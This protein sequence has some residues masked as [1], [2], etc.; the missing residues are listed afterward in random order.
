MGTKGIQL[1]FDEDGEPRLA[2]PEEKTAEC[3]A[4]VQCQYAERGED[5]RNFTLMCN[6]NGALCSAFSF[7]RCPKGKWGPIEGLGTNNQIPRA[8]RHDNNTCYTCMTTS[9][10]WQLKPPK[11]EKNNHWICYDCHPPAPGIPKEKILTRKRS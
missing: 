7:A 9:M 3:L 4:G 11:G 6:A 1:V 2:K 5:E 8:F 10:V